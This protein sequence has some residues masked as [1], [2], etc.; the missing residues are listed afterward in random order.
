MMEHNMAEQKDSLP[1]GRAMKLMLL[2]SFLFGA[3]II[4]GRVTGIMPALSEMS[5]AS[6]IGLCAVLTLSVL[7]GGGWYLKR[8]DEHDLHAN[9]WSILWGWVS[10]SLITL[11]WHMLYV[12][13]AAPIPDAMV[14]LLIS[15]IVSLLA[16]L[17]LRFR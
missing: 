8:T 4:I 2:G 16:W 10:V 13:K 5:P 9:L 6:A 15:A 7:V 12:A 11:N 14:T 1:Q 17:W 3:T